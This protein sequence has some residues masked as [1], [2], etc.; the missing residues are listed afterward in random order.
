MNMGGQTERQIEFILENAKNVLVV[1]LSK[2]PAKTSREV[3]NYLSDNGYKIT[4]INPTNIETT[5]TMPTYA[6]LDDLPK[7]YTPDIVCVFK[8]S[9]ECGK[10]TREI[11][12]KCRPKLAVWLQLGITNAQAETLSRRA[13]LFFVQDRCMK[14]ERQK[15]K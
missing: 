7:N 12:A 13:G 8:P 5:S 11:L 10:I 2:D 14:T 3:A 4:G 1:G 15:L 9:E 6:A